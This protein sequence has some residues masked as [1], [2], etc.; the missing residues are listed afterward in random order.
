MC[1]C[2]DCDYL[3]LRNRRLNVLYVNHNNVEDL[4][5]HTYTYTHV[6]AYATKVA[7]AC[8]YTTSINCL[9]ETINVKCT[10]HNWTVCAMHIQ[11][12]WLSLNLHN[13]A[14]YNNSLLGF[15]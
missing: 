14:V 2:T 1:T 6:H 10:L 13:F 5:T 12:L 7:H 8:T 11:W 3:S 15:R 9:F 4:T